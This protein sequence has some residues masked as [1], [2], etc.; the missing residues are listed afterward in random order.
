MITFWGYAFEQYMFY[1]GLVL[2]GIIICL[3]TAQL[4]KALFKKN[5]GA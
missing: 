2:N 1:S 5:G 4:V 3:G